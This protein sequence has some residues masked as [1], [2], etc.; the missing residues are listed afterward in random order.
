M[1]TIRILTL[2]LPAVAL[3]SCTPAKPVQNDTPQNPYG[4]ANPA[5]QAVATTTPPAGPPANPVY[6]TPAAYEEKN[7]SPA[8]PNANV[9]AAPALADPSASPASTGPA[10]LHTVVKGDS[11]WG[12]SKQYKIPVAS[13]KAANHM[14]NDTV[15]LGRKLVIPPH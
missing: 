8:A 3:I 9:P 13:I 6:D 4:A 7:P 15:V 12:I 2:S 5:T 11:L 10:T 14:T 1:T